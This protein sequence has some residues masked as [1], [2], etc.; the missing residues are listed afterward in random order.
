M[1][2]QPPPEDIVVA[3]TIY[4]SIAAKDMETKVYLQPAHMKPLPTTVDAQVSEMDSV[5][6]CTASLAPTSTNDKQF[7][8]KWQRHSKNG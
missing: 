6:R 7:I 5:V 3:E 2:R 4:N 8:P 1:N